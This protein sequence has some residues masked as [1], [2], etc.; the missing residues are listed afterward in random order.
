MHYQI[1]FFSFIILQHLIIPAILTSLQT[2]YVDV[3][4]WFLSI[5]RYETDVLSPVLCRDLAITADMFNSSLS[6]H[7]II[8][9]IPPYRVRM[10]NIALN[11]GTDIL[12]ARLQPEAL[13]MQVVILCQ[14]GSS[15][16][17][18]YQSLVD[19]TLCL[20]IFNTRVLPLYS[21]QTNWSCVSILL[22]EGHNSSQRSQCFYDRNCY[23]L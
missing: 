19:I 4:V 16:V 22:L 1:G 14:A 5:N 3:N 12:A 11:L 15:S 7:T 13:N 9:D 17:S 6:S 20:V 21:E 2:S 10:C 18:E 23:Y 8:N